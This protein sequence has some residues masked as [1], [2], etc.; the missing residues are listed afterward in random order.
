MPADTSKAP[1]ALDAIRR[2]GLMDDMITRCSVDLLAL[3]GKDGGQSYVEARA[4][5][6]ACSCVGTCRDWL[7]MPDGE[8]SSE[9]QDFCPNSGLFR[10][11]L[12]E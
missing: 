1:T 11:L 8:Q 10:A 4:K 6:R 2:Q 5:C 9:P 3:I 7:L 12:S